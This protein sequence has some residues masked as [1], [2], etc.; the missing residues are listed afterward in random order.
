MG[1]MCTILQA[2]GA[3]R[4]PH[5]LC[6]DHMVARCSMLEPC[7]P[8]GSHVGAR[9]CHMRGEWHHMGAAY[10]S[11]VCC[12][13]AT[14]AIWEPDGRC[15]LPYRRSMH[16]M[17]PREPYRSHVHHTG[18]YGSCVRHTG[19]GWHYMRAASTALR[20]HGSWHCMGAVGTIWEPDVSIWEVDGVK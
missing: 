3:R 13:G 20:P 16:P 18:A 8:Y 2:D 14:C 9:W 1:A 7:V 19:G 6:G 10:G 17:G 12:M 4:E 15:M 11:G 5:A